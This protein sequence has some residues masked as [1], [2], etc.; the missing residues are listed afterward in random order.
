MQSESIF[1]SFL[2]TFVLISFFVT[3][4]IKKISLKFFSNFLLDKDFGKPQAFHKD[5]IPRCGGLSSII[6]LIIGK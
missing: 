4:I 3:L 1:F 2:S 6:L 5:S